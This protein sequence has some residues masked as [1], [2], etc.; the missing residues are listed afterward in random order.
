MARVLAASVVACFSATASAQVVGVTFDIDQPVLAPGEFTTVRLLANFPDADYAF[1]GAALNVLIDGVSPFGSIS[2]PS[3]LP[4]MASGPLSIRVT[5]HG[6]EGIIAGQLNFPPAGI[7]ADPTNPI[8]FFQF[9]FY[10]NPDA[11]G[12]YRVDLLTEVSKFDVYPQRE[13]SLSESRLD[14]LTEGRA[15]I[16]V[17]PA[18]GSALV[19]AAGLLLARRR[20]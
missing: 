7:Y 5:E 4:P 3:L 6:I 9:T 10:A 18:P 19:L 13:L 2:D 20:R 14:L 12:G 1:A 11:G 17:V 8:P 16:F 15:S